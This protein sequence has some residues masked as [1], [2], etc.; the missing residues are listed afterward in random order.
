MCYQDP[1]NNRRQA[2]SQERAI[3]LEKVEAYTFLLLAALEVSQSLVI[4]GSS[5]VI[6]ALFATFSPFHN[7]FLHL[8]LLTHQ[9]HARKLRSD[10]VHLTPLQLVLFADFTDFVSFQH[11]TGFVRVVIVV[12]VLLFVWPLAFDIESLS[13]LHNI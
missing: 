7:R 5:I 12:D 1:L 3:L 11:S 9:T 13:R 10:I 6:Q 8:L 4:V 2:P